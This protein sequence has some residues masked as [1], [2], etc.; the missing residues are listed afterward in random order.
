M[1]DPSTEGSPRV[2]A[3]DADC[4]R[5]FLVG[6]DVVGAGNSAAAV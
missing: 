2:S 3:H 6:G 1:Q 5:L 4:N